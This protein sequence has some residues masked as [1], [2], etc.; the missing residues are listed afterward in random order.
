MTT[1]QVLSYLSERL[2]YPARSCIMAINYRLGHFRDAVWLFGDGRSGTTWVSDLVNW[3]K[4]YR[5]MFEPFHPRMVWGMRQ[6][7]LHQ[8]IR[9][10]DSGHRFLRRASDVFSGK[11]CS[12][13]VDHANWRLWYQGLL[14]KD[15]FANLLACWASQQFPRVK[16]VLLIRNPFAV[17]LSKS[18]RKTF[19]WLTDPS[20]LLAQEPLVQDHLQPFEDVI[21]GVG[22][23]FIQRQVLIWAILHYVPLRQFESGRLQVVFYEDVVRHPERELLRLFRYLRPD[24]VDSMMKGALE[25]VARP[26][27]VTGKKKKAA[28]GPWP[29]GQWRD[30]V[31]AE[32]L[33]EGLKIL[34]HFGLDQLYGDGAMPRREFLPGRETVEPVSQK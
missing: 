1:R 11:F 7:C 32:Q 17:A 33:R 16:P 15:I 4:S 18:K 13:R 25:I 31:S 34:A 29:I 8:Y 30:E 23:D 28:G 27:R 26:S 10:G 12:A 6:I 14:I 19:H 20:E 24:S 5:E 2:L 3:D 9:P 21:R 22:D